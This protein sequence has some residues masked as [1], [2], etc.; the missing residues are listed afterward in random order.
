MID[1]AMLSCN[2]RRITELAIGELARRTTTPHTLLA[3]DNGSVDGSK[4]M[5]LR[6]WQANRLGYRP[7]LS[8]ENA[9]VHWGHN[10]LLDMVESTPYYVCTDNDL[11]PC[12]PIDGQDWLSRLIDLADRH[13]EYAAIACR[14]H[15]LIGEPSNR[16]DDAS[17][18]REMS[19]VGA[20][21]RLMRTE[22]VREVGG[23]EKGKRPSRNHEERYICGKLRK[24]GW[25]VGYAR[26]IRCIHLFGD[27]SLGED[28][29][30][31]TAGTYHEGHREI[32]PPVTAFAW[33]RQGIDWEACK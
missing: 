8:R 20:H 26:D 13:P 6:M 15:I 4:E 9:G 24:A 3:Y 33:N 18:I 25:K 10:Q 12:A 32:S 2:R 21:L 1:I 5:L 22:V 16:F 27:N 19:H 31:Y 28:D 7:M 17:D 30:G 14:P 11:I 29:W 23:W